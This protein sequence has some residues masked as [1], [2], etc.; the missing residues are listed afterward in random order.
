MAIII[1][2]NNQ[3]IFNQ[4]AASINKKLSAINDKNCEKVAIGNES[5]SIYFSGGLE[6]VCYCLT[7]KYSF[8]EISK[9][10]GQPGKYR[11]APVFD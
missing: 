9:K 5:L 2:D 4:E 3:R 7:K 8:W 10:Q 11:W 1:E 6:L